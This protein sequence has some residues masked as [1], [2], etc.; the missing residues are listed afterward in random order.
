MAVLAAGL[1]I[2]LT[3]LLGSG[4]GITSSLLLGA[5]VIW[6]VVAGV[7]VWRW[8]RPTASLLEVAG[9]ALAVGSALAALSGL[10][11]STLGLGPW[12]WTLPSA[13]A[14]V[15]WLVHRRRAA[16]STET[17]ALTIDGPALWGLLAGVVP[18]L[19]IVAYS[20]RLYPLTWT[21]SWTGY[22][23]DMP[24]F[25]ALSTSLARFG[26]FESPFMVDGVVRYHW[27]SYAWAGQ[28]TVA[29][30]AAPFVTITRVLPVVAL[31]GCAAMIAA[32][33]R[34][35]SRQAWTPA[36]AGLLLSIGGFTGAVFGGVL[37]MDS[38]SQSMSVLW[39]I[40]FAIAVVHVTTS[41]VRLLPAV[42]L[43]GTLSLALIGGKVSAAAPAVAA[44][45]VMTGVQ[46]VRGDVSRLRALWTLAATVIGSATGFVLFLSGSVGGGGLT[47]GSLVDRA[48]SQQGLNPV[49]TRYTVVAGTLIL[50][51]AVL[52]R[53]AGVL[54]LLT[55]PEWRWRP[56][57]TL[58]VG[59]G[60]SSIA[61]LIAFNSFN[62]VWFSSTVSGPLAAVTAVGSGSAV[63]YL[64]ERPRPSV[65]AVLAIAAVCAIAIFAVV[66]WHW[67]TGASG[68]NVFTPTLRWLGPLAA[69]LLAIALGTLLG[70][71]GRGRVSALGTLAGA[72]V[73]LVFVSVPGRL[74]G[75]GTGLVGIQE[76]GLRD[77]WFSV[78]DSTYPKGPDWIP[79]EDWTSTR[80]DAAN[81]LRDAAAPTDV[82]ATNLT[83]GP[84]V[85]GVTHLP[86]FVSA[87]WYQT[88]YGL[89]WMTEELLLREQQSWAFID[90]PS[91]ET[92]RPLCR[93]G[94][95][96]LWVDLGRTEA[97]DW[98]PYAVTVEQNEDTAVAEIDPDACSAR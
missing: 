92:L 27:L 75:A 72:A 77:E 68:G 81:R 50:V 8:L 51:L 39:L 37:T 58:S 40:A 66:W 71:W 35:L 34:S 98:F 87:R 85:A 31:L 63:A 70:W 67:G 47:I 88:P 42:V 7:A 29:A 61:A 10:L 84:F 80:M 11:T 21:G 94:V 22:H 24:F 64:S 3:V 93:A 82:L 78:G 59:L 2:L 1:A 23:P 55:R 19:A 4:V 43:V 52:P 18:G 6:Q 54:W 12:G 16:A 90:E 9:A 62:E 28:L 97:R 89:A 96:W 73:L 38:P 14:A 56:E 45:I 13:V 36:L 20:L 17:T 91:A 26:A 15:T 57:V 33:T 65:R 60:A 25:E 86:T 79:I 69:G 95:R 74:L 32:W 41:Q 83:F 49:D 5:C 53:W 30:D 44:V 46:V 48:S 76:N